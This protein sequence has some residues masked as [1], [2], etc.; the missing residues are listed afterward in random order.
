M[1]LKNF[2]PK[3]KPEECAILV[4]YFKQKGLSVDEVALEIASV[5]GSG[6]MSKKTLKQ[7]YNKSDKKCADHQQESESGQAKVHSTN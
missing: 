4:Q 1:K 5:Y 6:F 3:P 7:F 2:D